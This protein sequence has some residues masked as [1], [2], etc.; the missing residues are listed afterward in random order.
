MTIRARGTAQER[1][2]KVDHQVRRGHGEI[3]TRVVE[4]EVIGQ[5]HEHLGPGHEL[6]VEAVERADWSWSSCVLP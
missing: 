4:D 6:E 3:V 5:A 2:G 1:L